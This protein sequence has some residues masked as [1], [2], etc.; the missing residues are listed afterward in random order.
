MLSLDS[1]A[2][3]RRNFGTLSNEQLAARLGCTVQQIEAAA[4]ELALAKN[5]KLFE[6]DMPRWSA[7]DLD[8]L[9]RLY[10]LQSNLAIARE[11]GRSVKSIMAKA[12]RLKLTKAPER[13]RAMGAE[14]VRLRRDRNSTP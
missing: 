6:R 9:R 12:A 3:L 10:P 14:N 1:L 8:K 5:K 4:A 2:F 13:K 7:V 11:L